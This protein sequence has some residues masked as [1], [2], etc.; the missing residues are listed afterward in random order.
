LFV[1]QRGQTQLLE[2]VGTLDP[3]RRFASHLHGRKQKVDQ[4]ANNRNNDQEFDKR[5]TPP[6][7]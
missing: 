2:T 1:V 7:N 4:Y 6:E 5:K 3:P